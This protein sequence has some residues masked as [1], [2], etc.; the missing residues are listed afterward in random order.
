MRFL[1]LQ[2]GGGKEHRHNR[3]NR[4]DRQANRVAADHPLAMLRKLTPKRM[5]ER[6]LQ[7][8]EE[9]CAE[10]KY[11]RLFVQ[12]ANRLAERQA[13]SRGAHHGAGCQENSSRPAMK[14]RIFCAEAAHK[15]QWPQNHEQHGWQDMGEHQDLFAREMRI[16][17]GGGILAWRRCRGL[18]QHYGAAS[19][20]READEREKYDG[21]PK[22]ARQ[23]AAWS[24]CSAVSHAHIYAGQAAFVTRFSEFLCGYCE[25][26]PRRRLAG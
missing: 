12:T 10:Q 25:Q 2:H 22:K 20:Y 16:H 8:D 24:S 4:G 14:P 6:F 23:L 3:A 13:N 21:H 9:E 17:I 19:G 26:A 11:G 1:P 5:P 18:Q 7:R 15:L